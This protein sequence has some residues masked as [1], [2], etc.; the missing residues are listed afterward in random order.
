MLGD[1]IAQMRKRGEEG[2]VI[3]AVMDRYAAQQ[4]YDDIQKMFMYNHFN[5]KVEFDKDDINKS[6]GSIKQQL[7]NAFA[8]NVYTINFVVAGVD[9]K[10]GYSQLKKEM[11][12]QLSRLKELVEMRKNLKGGNYVGYDPVALNTEIN[13]LYKD[14]S[15]MGKGY[16]ELAD[17]IMGYNK[18]TTNSTNTNKIQRDILSEQISLLKEM[19]SRYDSLR[20]VMSDGTAQSSVLSY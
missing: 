20:D 15:N 16:K 12:S 5:V 14:I 19:Q 7:D 18:N 6:I 4:G 11:D 10:T 13:A 9:A 17:Q 2:V 3:R 1:V 8:N